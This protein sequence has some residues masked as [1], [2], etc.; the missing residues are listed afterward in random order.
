MRTL[1]AGIARA[2][3]IGRGRGVLFDAEVVLGVAE[4]ARVGV[5]KGHVANVGLFVGG[6]LDVLG[7][8]I[9]GLERLAHFDVERD[10][11]DGL[12]PVGEAVPGQ[13]HVAA[14]AA[15]FQRAGGHLTS[16]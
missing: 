5:G 4:E 1:D 9:R 13:Q 10:H 15:A 2:G 16:D 12:E 8:G 11:Q 14:A 7:R 6:E 3:G